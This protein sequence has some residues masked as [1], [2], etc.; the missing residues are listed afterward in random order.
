ML[1]IGL[2]AGQFAQLYQLFDIVQAA[3]LAL[4]TGTGDRTIEGI[5]LQAK[6]GYVIGY[7]EEFINLTPGHLGDGLF[8]TGQQGFTGGNLDSICADLER[9]QRI[10]FGIFVRHDRGKGFDIDLKRIDMDKG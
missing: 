2:R 6:A 3:A 4:T 5:K 1:I 10:A 8:P 7:C 9:Q